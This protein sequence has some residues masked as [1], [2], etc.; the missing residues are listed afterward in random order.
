MNGTMFARSSMILGSL[1][2]F[3][4][5]VGCSRGSQPKSPQP[6]PTFESRVSEP[7]GEAR[8]EEPMGAMTPAGPSNRGTQGASPQHGAEGM[9]GGEG[10][11]GPQD[12]SQG[13]AG[14]Q[15]S[16][17]QSAPL[18]YPTTPMGSEPTQTAPKEGA[19]AP[20]SER[21]LCTAMSQ[22][23]N[24]RIEDVQ[25]GVAVVMTPRGGTDMDAIRKDARQVERA[26]G[27]AAGRH[28]DAPIEQRCELMEIGRQA[29]STTV[30]E[31]PGEV[32]IVM[33]SSD[34]AGTRSLRQR[35]RAYVKATNP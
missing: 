34:A 29:T 17:G 5:N 10:P 13:A 35:A 3:A 22:D 16:A 30:V 19:S 15:G 23:A 9:E 6:S 32:R 27:P 1:A 11:A 20:M 4:L 26:I 24:L 31:G 2:L 28:V 25:G 12:G 21:G 18:P 33:T 7:T 14:S 8:E